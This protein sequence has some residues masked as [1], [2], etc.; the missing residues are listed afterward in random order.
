MVFPRIGVL[1][2]KMFT[3]YKAR[4]F[5]FKLSSSTY[6]LMAILTSDVKGCLPHCIF[7]V[8]VGNV[9]NKIMKQFCSSINSKPMDLGQK[10]TEHAFSKEIYSLLKCIS[11]PKNGLMIMETEYLRSLH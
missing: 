10:I 6:C 1:A 8:Y 11:L 7:N 3:V 4:T 2:Y 5:R 9:L